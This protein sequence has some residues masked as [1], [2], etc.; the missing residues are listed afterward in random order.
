VLLPR[1]YTDSVSFWLCLVLPNSYEFLSGICDKTGSTITEGDALDV[2]Y[3][4][5]NAEAA[6]ANSEKSMSLCHELTSE[7]PILGPILMTP[8]A[9]MRLLGST[10]N[11]PHSKH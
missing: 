6:I 2:V 8:Q 10:V 4:S 5:L 3:E 9:S 7:L 1:V 11:Y